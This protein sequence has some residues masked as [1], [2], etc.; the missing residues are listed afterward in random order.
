MHHVKNVSKIYTNPLL[1]SPSAWKQLWWKTPLSGDRGSFLEI[2]LDRIW[3]FQFSVQKYILVFECCLTKSESLN[4][5]VRHSKLSTSWL[6][7]TLEAALPSLVSKH[8]TFHSDQSVCH[9]PGIPPCFP[10]HALANY[11]F[12]SWGLLAS[13]LQFDVMYQSLN[14]MPIL[15]HSNSLTRKIIQNLHKDLA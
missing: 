2:I 15:W 9:F 7:T 11:I 4:S 10:F 13:F 3:S 1:P 12:T 8:F 14:N 5:T 6:Q